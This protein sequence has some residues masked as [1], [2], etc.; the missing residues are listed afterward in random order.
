MIDSEERRNMF[1]IR[2]LSRTQKINIFQII[3]YEGKYLFWIE[4]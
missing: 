1:F 4:Y 3:N 2:P